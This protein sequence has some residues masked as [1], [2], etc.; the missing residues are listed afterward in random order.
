MV[1]TT[2]RFCHAT[3]M[4]RGK[5]SRLTTSRSTTQTRHSRR[6][7]VLD[8]CLSVCLSVCL[9]GWLAG[10]LAWLPALLPGCLKK[11]G[12]AGSSLPPSQ[13]L[14]VKQGFACQLEGGG[15]TLDDYYLCSAPA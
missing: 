9:A 13:R 10:W 2:A 3:S 15:K 1:G 5:T 14:D 12:V 11:R 4:R 8:V 6:P 7:K